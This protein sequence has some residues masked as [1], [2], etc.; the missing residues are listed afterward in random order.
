MSVR[1]CVADINCGGIVGRMVVIVVMVVVM[2]V[3][4]R[5]GVMRVGLGTVRVVVPLCAGA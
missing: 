1:I 3:M 2:I 5:P 4:T